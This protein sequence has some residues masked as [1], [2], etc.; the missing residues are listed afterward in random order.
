M[1]YFL[2]NSFIVMQLCYHEVMWNLLL[3][4]MSASLIAF[5]IT[6]LLAVL[7]RNNS[8]VDILWGLGFVLIALIGYTLA[9]VTIVTQLVLIYVSLWG[10]RLAVHIGLRNWG[11]SEDFR[12]AQM[13]IAWGKHW[14]IRSFFQ[15]YLVQ[16]ILMQLVSLPIILAMA[17]TFTISP[18]LMYIGMAIWFTGFFFEAVGDYQLT[19]FKKKKSSKGK[20]MKTGLWSL[21]RHPNYFGEATL[22]WGIA[23][24]GYGVSHNPLVFLG[25]L[26]IDFLLLYVSGIPLLEAK[27]QGR[28]DWAAYTKKTPAFF[29]KI[30]LWR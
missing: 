2:Y 6:F 9:P 11:K 10:L 3:F 26:T 24:L 17:G 28:S 15:I 13:R 23:L 20:L 25:P 12:Y 30:D 7:I 18:V 4:T 21:T 19:Q 8:I 14:V 5:V 27:Y 16:W 29:P 1:W 22:W